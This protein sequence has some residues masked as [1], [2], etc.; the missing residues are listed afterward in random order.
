MITIDT[1]TLAPLS[2]SLA[3]VAGCVIITLVGIKK[4]K[5]FM[6]EDAAKVEVRNK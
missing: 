1:Y 5:R 2:A 3:V 4:I 6:S